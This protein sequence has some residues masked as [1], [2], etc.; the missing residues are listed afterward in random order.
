MFAR[1]R[2]RNPIGGSPSSNY[3]RSAMISPASS[4]YLLV[5]GIV[6]GPSCCL[7][8]GVLAAINSADYPKEAGIAFIPA[9][10]SFQTGKISLIPVPHGIS[11]RRK[12]LLS[13]GIRT[14]IQFQFRLEVHLHWLMLLRRSDDRIGLKLRS[15]PVRSPD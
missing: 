2:R 12:P 10:S 4:I 14:S 5:G 15:F 1:C 7:C 8:H 11:G 13:R 6:C 3:G 9:G